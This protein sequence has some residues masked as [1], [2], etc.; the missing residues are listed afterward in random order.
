M[1]RG[2]T[3]QASAQA[4]GTTAL[5]LYFRAMRDPADSYLLTEVLESGDL[6]LEGVD[7]GDEV[8]FEADSPLDLL[9]SFGDDFR[10]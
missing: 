1:A 6:L 4:G 7:S 3:L 8:A 10:A 9:P 5:K 2:L